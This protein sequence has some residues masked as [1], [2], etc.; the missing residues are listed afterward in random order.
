MSS[1]AR[2]GDNLIKKVIARDN[3]R[4]PFINACAKILQEQRKLGLARPVAGVVVILAYEDGVVSSAATGLSH[5][6]AKRAIDAAKD[7]MSGF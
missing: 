7:A 3:E 6:E 2:G 1:L 4:F 5:A